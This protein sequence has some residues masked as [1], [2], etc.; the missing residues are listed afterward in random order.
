VVQADADLATSDI[1]NSKAKDASRERAIQAIQVDQTIRAIPL[2]VI[3]HAAAAFSLYNLATYPT[4][5]I[6]LPIWYVSA[7]AVSLCF[8]VA[9]ILWRNPKW[10]KKPT[11]VLHG[12]ELLCFGFGVVWALP[13]AA[14]TQLKSPT[15][16]IAIAC[17]TLAMMAV[18]AMSLLRVPT[19]LVVF[20]SLVST[21][22][23]GALYKSL[24]S[25]HLVAVLLC[26]I[27]CLVLLSVTL[28]SHIDFRRRT[29]IELEG[30]RQ[31]DVIRLLLNDF[32][33]GTPDWLWEADAVGKISYASPRLA[34]VLGLQ[35]DSALG[36]R[37][38]QVLADFA[39]ADILRSLDLSLDAAETVNEFAMPV[40]INTVN[41]EWRFTAQPV[42][43]SNGI[44]IGH[45]G[46]CRDV[47]KAH[48]I[49]KRTELAIET[50]EQA[51][52]AKSQ[53]LAVMSHELRT[54]LNAIVGFSEL[55]ARDGADTLP[56]KSRKEYSEIILNNASQLQ[57]LINDL[58]DTTRM[59][60]GTLQLAEQDVDAAEIVEIAIKLCSHQAEKSGV[61]IVGRLTDNIALSVDL[62]RLKQT[63]V[64]LLL[65]AIKF[66]ENGGIINVEMQRGQDSQFILAI[67]DGGIG[68]A[69]DD[70]ERVFDPFIQADSST[71]RTHGGAGLGL[72]IARRI[73]RLH[74]GDVTLVSTMGAGTTA[75]LIL[76]KHRV[77][78]PLPQPRT[79]QNVA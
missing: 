50:T 76:P 72:P 29:H 3:F 13:L 2:L 27:Y 9:F 14:A 10:R 53:F 58:L 20:L 30:A 40:K 6:L 8:A 61:S 43:D 38:R 16:T 59:E 49:K 23:A 74:G 48:D 24:E 37:L 67:K 70:I 71:T 28:T 25:Q 57:V 65:N 46:V 12:L 36:L 56:L 35:P 34:E 26:A 63:V 19:G 79:I 7:L 54:P 66:S 11:V 64:N 18:A 4:A 39:P 62:S 45:R 55:L 75:T 15:N 78:W 60:S 51:N 77:H 21:T 5:S 17:I 52:S 44:V 32:E 73:A 22:M 33:R 68:I 1:L 31:K 47:T 41:L 69:P 42:S